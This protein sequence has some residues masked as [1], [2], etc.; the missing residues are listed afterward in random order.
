MRI[1]DT[2]EPGFD[3]NVT[4]PADV[5]RTIARGHVAFAN[6]GGSTAF[7]SK[8]FAPPTI[9]SIIEPT[10]HRRR[11]RR[12]KAKKQRASGRRGQPP[13]TY[14]LRA[15]AIYVDDLER[16]GVRFATARRSRM[17]IE[18]RKWLHERTA[19]TNDARK[20]R[21]K[22]VTEDAVTVL[23]KEVAVFRK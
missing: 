9:I 5:Q 15:V 19:K 21:R 23:L 6:S 11:E 3:P 4:L 8:A 7:A 20:S 2:A 1:N 10:E 13:M 18:V 16:Q 22:M 14:R 17:N 12:L